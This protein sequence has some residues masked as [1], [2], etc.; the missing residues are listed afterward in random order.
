MTIEIGMKLI[1]PEQPGQQGFYYRRAED[2]EKLMHVLSIMPATLTGKN[3]PG[4]L[5]Q[6][7]NSRMNGS[8]KIGGKMETPVALGFLLL[9]LNENQRKRYIQESKTLG[10]RITPSEAYL[11]FPGLKSKNVSDV[12]QGVMGRVWD[13]FYA[14]SKGESGGSI[15]PDLI[16]KW[17]AYV[18]KHYQEPLSDPSEAGWNV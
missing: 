13:K 16:E 8:Q 10:R 18:Q 15:H 7:A 6:S 9:L 17:S 12:E 3:S 11:M 14:V 5:K 2:F 1:F 4:R